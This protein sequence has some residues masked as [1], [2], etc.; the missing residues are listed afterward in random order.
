MFFWTSQE[1]RLCTFFLLMGWYLW[2]VLWANLWI[3]D[4]AVT[5]RPISVSC[6]FLPLPPVA[7]Y[8][9]V[10]EN[11]L[12][13]LTMWLVWRWELGKYKTNHSPRETVF[14]ASQ[15]P[16]WTLH[17]AFHPQCYSWVCWLWLEATNVAVGFLTA[18]QWSVSME[19]RA[20]DLMV[21]KILL[22]AW[23][24]FSTWRRSWPCAPHGCN[25]N[26]PQV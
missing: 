22:L 21:H 8:S 5:G 10:T 25:L 14:S 7:G 12:V 20:W 13:P 1:P 4:L 23:P 19:W 2:E 11:T 18:W 3:W 15:M 9:S 17:L 24:R 6:S 16:F 26:S